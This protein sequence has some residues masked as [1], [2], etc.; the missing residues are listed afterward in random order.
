MKVRVRHVVVGL[1]AFVLLLAFA[2]RLF[3]LHAPLSYFDEGVLLT[4]S[5][6]VH[7]GMVTFRDFYSI[8]PPGIYYLV[9]A[10]WHLLGVSVLGMRLL[11]LLVA[12]GLAALAGRHAGAL[13]GG[14]FSFVGAGVVL[15]F[16]IPLMNVPYA[17]LVALSLVFVAL[18]LLLSENPRH[19]WLGG[20]ALGVSSAFR[21]DLFSYVGASWGALSV[22]ALVLARRRPE[23]R[24]PRAAPVV[25]SLCLA[26]GLAV[27]IW[28]AIVWSGGAR[29]VWRDLVYN[30]SHYIMQS[31]MLPFPDLL[32]LRQVPGIGVSVP[33]VLVRYFEAGVVLCFVAPLIGLFLTWELRS[34][35]R[36]AARALLLT[37]LSVTVIPQMSARTDGDHVL[38]SVTPALVLILAAAERTLETGTRQRRWVGV[39]ARAVVLLPIPHAFLCVPRTHDTLVLG[40]PR[41]GGV[42]E[43]EPDVVRA[44]RRVLVLVERYTRAGDPIF[45]GTLNH[46]RVHM[47]EMDLYFLFNRTGGARFMQFDPNLN[48]REDVQREMVDDLVAR[49]TRLAILSSRPTL[50][51]QENLLAG[52]K[53]LDQHLERHFR[54]VGAF[55]P[56][57]V[58]LR[59]DVS[60]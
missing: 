23:L 46:E 60:P 39:A 45:V 32:A 20:V 4:D 40:V 8:Y 5:D 33:Y 56:Y 42:P 34:T 14:R 7:R 11:G 16:L 37:A 48:T 10:V 3:L 28:T 15:A 26:A 55:P 35:P 43:P 12:L 6:L 17:W 50:E 57:R 24:I 54:E 21:H 59:R 44:R 52:S 13:T 1:G 36:L 49:D 31:R 27:L 47:V 41:D 30:V 51:P 9:S 22:A 25:R 38:L 58:L 19:V 29:N 2:K 53:H 18:E